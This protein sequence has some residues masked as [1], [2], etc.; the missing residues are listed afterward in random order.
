MPAWKMVSLMPLLTVA[1][2]AIAA[3]SQNSI[4]LPRESWPTTVVYDVALKNCD[5]MGGKVSGRVGTQFCYIAA[6]DCEAHA[7]YK[8]VMRDAFTIGGAR[9]AACRKLK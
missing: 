6:T 5:G 8:V 4:A 2:S 1:A 7:G 3:D 9:L